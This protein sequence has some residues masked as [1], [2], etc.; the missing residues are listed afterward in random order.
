M[1]LFSLPADTPFL[2]ALAAAW[3]ADAA[4]EPTRIAEGLILLPTRRAARA[5]A[6]AF[7]R[8]SAGRPLLLPR[9]IAFGALDEAPLALA[10]A[11][12]LAPAV[13]PMLR[14]AHLTRLILALDG[15]SGAPRSAERAWPLAV[16]LAALMDEAEREGVDLAAALPRATE[17][18]FARHWQQTLEFLAIVTSAWPRWLAANA[19]MNP[20]ARGVALIEAQAEAWRR[21]APETPIWAA[22]SAGGIPAVAR[23]LGVVARLPRGRVVLPGF[24]GDVPVENGAVFPPETHP[25]AGMHRLLAAIGATP[26]DVRP[27]GESPWGESPWGG[28]PRKTA[29][30][31]LAP[32]RAAIL[33]RALLPA[34][35]LDRWR[36]GSVPDIPGITRLE[37]ADEHQEAQAIALILRGALERPEG[38]PGARAALVTPDRDLALRV[39]AELARYGV[40]VDDSAGEALGET[41]PSVFLRLLASAWAEDLAPVPLLALLKHP[42]AAAGL[43]TDAARDLARRL[44]LAA[45][46]GP[47]P[48]G[49]IV[50]LRR[51]LAEVAEREALE[52]F[53]TR[54]AEA[55]AP[56]SRLAAG[57]EPV[58]AETLLTALIEAGEALAATDAEAGAAR[59]WAFE[60]G[61]ALAELLAEAL[62]ALAVLPPLPAASLPGL[63][64][65]LLAG[66]VVRSRRALRGRAGTE[67]PRVF[68]WGLL[69]ARRQS[70]ELI[71]LGGLAEGVWPPSV[72]PGPWLSRPMRAALGLP[73]PEAA[74]GQSAH[75]FVM[76]ACA[77]PEVVLSCPR[78]RERAPVVPARWLTRLD[79]MLEPPLARHPAAAWAAAIDQPEGK[80]RPVPPP[81]PR[82]PA[83]L[84]PRRLTVTEIETLFADPYAIYARHI[85]RLTPLAP[86]DPPIGRADFGVIVHRALRRFCDRLAALPDAATMAATLD[87]ELETALLQAAIRP[88]LAAWW[89][90]RLR[91]IAHWVA[92]WEAARGQAQHR[93]AERAGEW[94]LPV[95]GGFTLAGRADRIERHEDGGI[96]LIDFKTGTVPRESEVAEGTAPQLPLEA[97]MAEAGAFG[98]E[99]RAPAVSLL[100]LHL[101]GGVTPGAEHALFAGDH[102]TLGQIIAATKTRLLSVLETFADDA[103]PYRATPSPP[104]RASWRSDYAALARQS[105]WQVASVEANDDDG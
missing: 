74:I 2:D 18:Q 58:P 55:L 83:N 66:A 36:E 62:A 77:A 80:P 8:Q 94:L 13:P 22:G 88:A 86:L 71:V 42:Y 44:E 104:G 60:E 32:G 12:D 51:V 82:P 15:A 61:G 6:D 96:V 24:D 49:G 39:A 95:A 35:A 21:A 73:S 56:L 7:L 33:A 91:R 85:L 45:L 26:G 11:L 19:L 31:G 65:A 105:E 46:R 67:H 4:G 84:R 25:A 102:A 97:A 43:A 48:P 89:R 17:G 53:I 59:L 37:A 78:R 41:P 87:N 1:N 98:D 79:A 92:G 70:A 38:R 75:D 9:I 16:E 5:L 54:I 29:R 99:F 40:I 90:P 57:V 47:R 14:L 100:Y 27:W 63:L 28:E 101:T 23:L 3:L 64:D 72:D 103:T 81:A 69:E 76:A 68:I 10:G 20:S 93:A 34:G 30:A 50:G 52:D